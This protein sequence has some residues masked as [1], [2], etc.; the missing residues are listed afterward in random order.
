MVNSPCLDCRARHIGCHAE[1]AAY[2]A[3]RAEFEAQYPLRME[4]AAQAQYTHEKAQ[5]RKKR[6]HLP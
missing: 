6:R 5:K 4:A 2:L 3:Y 1:C